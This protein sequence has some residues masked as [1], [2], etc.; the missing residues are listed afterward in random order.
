[1]HIIMCGLHRLIDT[2]VLRHTNTHRWDVSPQSLCEFVDSRLSWNPSANSLSHTGKP[3]PLLQ[4]D[5][6]DGTPSTFL[7]NVLK[8]NFESR[9]TT[10]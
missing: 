8:I 3:S 10:F 1:M 4:L 2:H 6:E 9:K 5:C 7:C